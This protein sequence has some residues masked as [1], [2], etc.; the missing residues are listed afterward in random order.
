MATV[1][2]FSTR[3][4]A[5]TSL[6]MGSSFASQSEAPLD[7]PVLP[8][9]RGQALPA[10]M[11]DKNA[12]ALKNMN[13][14]TAKRAKWHVKALGPKAKQTN[15]QTLRRAAATGEG[16]R[17]NAGAELKALRIQDTPGLRRHLRRRLERW[18][19]QIVPGHRP[20]R[21]EAALS[22][23]G[24]PVP[25]CV[26]AAS[27]KALL[28]GWTT[29]ASGGRPSQCLFGCQ[30]GQDVI[31]HH[32]HCPCVAQLAR[33]RLRLEPAPAAVR[34]GDFLLLHG[35]SG[36]R[37]LALRAPCLR[38]TF[39]AANAA[40]SGRANAAGDARAQVMLDG[41]ARDAPLTGIVDTLWST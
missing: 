5:Q 6:T 39:M 33:A 3:H 28:G 38:A 7:P 29:A 37:R 36:A 11:L 18:N 34:P 41:A 20:Q 40:R 23:I 1:V 26:W 16:A 10:E 19:L 25:P 31:A 30:S 27:L 4:S 13:A 17:P 15:N 22:C 12:K 21:M 24:A 14:Q 2:G 9:Y 35:H 8:P 32:A